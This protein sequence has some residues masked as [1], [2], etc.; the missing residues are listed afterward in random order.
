MKK[1]KFLKMPGM[2]ALMDKD[3]YQIVNPSSPKDWERRDFGY[4][5]IPNWGAEFNLKVSEN[6]EVNGVNVFN[7]SL[8]EY[9]RDQVQYSKSLTNAVQ[10]IKSL[11]DKVEP[12]VVNCTFS[13]NNS[14]F[15]VNTIEGYYSTDFPGLIKDNFIKGAGYTYYNINFDGKGQKVSDAEVWKREGKCPQCGQIG[16]FFRTALICSNHGIYGGF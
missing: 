6:I 15:M 16:K 1:L 8:L 7:F 10:R 3:S 14:V 5:T 2:F 4:F 13:S 12:V 11:I 9:V